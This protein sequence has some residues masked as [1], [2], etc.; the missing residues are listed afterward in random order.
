MRRY[1]VFEYYKQDKTPIGI[2]DS[3]EEAYNEGFS[4]YL[5]NS[6]DIFFDESRG[7]YYNNY[8][9]WFKPDED[10]EFLNSDCIFLPSKSEIQSKLN[11]SGIFEF[12]LSNKCSIIIKK[13]TI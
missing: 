8:N 11:D 6:S 9:G 12:K 5:G 13:K 4:W 7:E 10:D 2:F 3:F 1:K